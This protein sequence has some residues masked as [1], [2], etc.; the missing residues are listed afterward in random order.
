MNSAR[1]CDELPGMLISDAL[2]RCCHPVVD[3]H[4]AGIDAGL[5]TDILLTFRTCIDYNESQWPITMQANRLGTLH[6]VLIGQL[7]VTDAWYLDMNVDT[8]QE[9][10]A[11]SS[12]HS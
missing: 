1:I 3:L 4:H 5:L 7:L 9:R 2:H 6:I 12:L 10:T 11:N 8:V